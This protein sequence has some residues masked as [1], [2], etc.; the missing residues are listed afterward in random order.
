MRW[1]CAFTLR[2]MPVLI[3]LAHKFSMMTETS[4]YFELKPVIELL[5]VR[6]S[7]TGTHYLAPPTAHHLMETLNVVLA[8]DPAT[9]VEYAAAVCEAGSKMGYHFDRDA[10]GEWS[11][12]LNTSLR[13][14]EKY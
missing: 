12:L 3:E 1:L 5:T 11:H 4:I 13:I 10:I 14:I 9:V 6:R 7:V 2:W 8:Y